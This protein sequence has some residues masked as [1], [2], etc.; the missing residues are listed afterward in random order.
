MSKPI[1]QQQLP[2]Q[3]GL[4]ISYFGNS[5][6]VLAENGQVIP[7]HLR[8]NQMLPVVGDHVIWQ[9]AET[10]EGAIILEI[11][12][13]RS[14]LARGDQHGKKQ[15]LAANVDKLVIVMAPP[16]IFS[17]YLLDRYLVAAELLHIAPVIVLNKVDLLDAHTQPLCEQRLAIYRRIPCPVVLTSALRGE[18]LSALSALLSGQLAVLV[19]PSGVGKS[20]IIMALGHEQAIKTGTVSDKGSGKHTTTATRLYQLPQDV[21]LIDSPG[22][23]E[24]NLWPVN[25]PELLQGFTEFS[26]F[27][28]QCKFRD[29]QHYLEPGCGLQAAVAQGQVSPTRLASYHT[30]LK[31]IHTSSKKR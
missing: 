4:V 21:S 24:F 31:D 15:P 7:C 5:V 16:P 13:R 30:L 9:M 26:P 11:K 10:G 14:L 23:R 18:G 8:R 22:V 20:S 2:G 28:N 12:P 19:G 6:A 25:Q 27:L 1:E 29:C 17:E 3:P